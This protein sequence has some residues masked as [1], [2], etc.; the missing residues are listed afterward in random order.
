MEAVNEEIIFLIDDY[1]NIYTQIKQ[2]R[3]KL[4]QKII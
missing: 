1:L 3:K 4:Y 2:L